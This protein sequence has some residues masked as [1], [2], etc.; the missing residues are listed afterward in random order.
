MGLTTACA[1]A[2]ERRINCLFSS[3]YSL[4]DVKKTPNTRT[5]K[6]ELRSRPFDTHQAAD[7]R[8]IQDT[9]GRVKGW[10]VMWGQGKLGSST[11]AVVANAS[12]LPVA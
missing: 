6:R 7:E 2:S 12:A 4:N 5:S 3:R 11:L 8:K 1:I 10:V 9:E